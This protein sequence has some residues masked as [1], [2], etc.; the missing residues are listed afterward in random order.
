[1]THNIPL[2]HVQKLTKAISDTKRAEVAN[3]QN[4]I[5]E[6]LSS[7][8]TFLQGSYKNDTSTSDINDVDIVAV[9]PNTYS[10]THS[11]VPVSHLIMWD[12]IF[13][14]I[15]NKLILNPG[16]YRWTVKRADKCI[17]VRTSSFKADVV[18]AVQVDPVL[19]NDNIAIYSFKNACEKVN[20]P[21]THYKNGVA[22]HDDTNQNYKP[23]V[24]MFKNWATNHFG[25]SDIVSSYHIESLVYN[26]P[27][28]NFYNDHAASFAL[29]GSYIVKLLRRRNV[30]PVVIKSV[31][32]SEDITAN[33]SLSNQQVFCDILDKSVTHALNA[34]QAGNQYDAQNHW[35]KAFNL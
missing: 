7:H 15:E 14:E 22:K 9:R 10:G 13:S 6:V 17:E 24:R 30:T 19:K 35:G 11:S 18:P 12:Q 20:F 23:I 26:S 8:H 5:Q 32:G 3:L 1:M 21:N 27:K 4:Y 29:I 2:A 33:W 34:Y 16:R 28:D 31:C 25:E